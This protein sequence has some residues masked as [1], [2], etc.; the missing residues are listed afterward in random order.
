MNSKSILFVSFLISTLFNLNAQT[1]TRYG[2]KVGI[3]ASNPI[4]KVESTSVKGITTMYGADIGI[5]ADWAL[6]EK[7]YITSGLHFI[8][9][10]LKT[11]FEGEK[12]IPNS[13]RPSINYL[14][15]PI[16]L[17]YVML[18]SEIA[19][20]ILGGPRIDF[21]ISKNNQNWNR[22]VYKNTKSVDFGINLGVGI[23]TKLLFGI[24]SGI[25]LRYSP[26]FF[27]VDSSVWGNITNR[28]FEINLIFFR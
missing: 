16:T 3:A 1:L 19:P 24:G 12:Q 6:S 18:N 17:K 27:N 2:L 20:Y 11:Q 13:E 7:A 14:S 22:F 8:Q 15:I 25:E 23:Q 21:A 9:K 4:W 10:G 5:F 26:S 28:S